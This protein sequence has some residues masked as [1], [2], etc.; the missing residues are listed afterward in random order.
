MKAFTWPSSSL[1]E[2]LLA[3]LAGGFPELPGI[4]T[5]TSTFCFLLPLAF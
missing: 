5:D 3:V 1:D 2:P 4:I